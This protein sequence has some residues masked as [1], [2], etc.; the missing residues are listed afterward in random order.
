MK[1]L[2]S[3]YPEFRIHH[4]LTPKIFGRIT[5]VHI[6]NQNR[7]KLDP[8]ALK[9][10]FI[11]YLAT[12]KGYKCYHPP[13]KKTLVSVTLPLMNKIPIFSN[14]IFRGRLNLRKMNK[15]N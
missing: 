6:H 4:N 2:S 11:G 5:Y 14:L 8:R 13:T 12:Q 7:G 9:C 10:I 3:F 15:M 1:N